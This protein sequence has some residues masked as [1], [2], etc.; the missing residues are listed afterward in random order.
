MT[1]RGNLVGGLWPGAR[2]DHR[3]GPIHYRTHTDFVQADR[4]ISRT[5]SMAR[6]G[7][8]GNATARGWVAAFA[9]C[10]DRDPCSGRAARPATGLDERVLACGRRTS[11][12]GRSPVVTTSPAGR[13]ISMKG[14]VHPQ[15]FHSATSGGG[16][17]GRSVL[18]AA[19]TSAWPLR[20][21]GRAHHL[22][23]RRVDPETA[24]GT[25][26]IFGM[27]GNALGHLFGGNGVP[28]LLTVTPPVS[29]PV[30]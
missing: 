21:V 3:G 28:Q 14:D 8:C 27:V 15:G 23:V 17:Q 16:C 9:I 4:E 18:G 26:A 2:S 5:R 30:V 24:P 25:P 7:S 29:S 20:R 1:V 11:A 10:W 22:L 12:S 6:H 19:S 13:P